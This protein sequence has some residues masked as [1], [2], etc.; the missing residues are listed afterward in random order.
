MKNISWS[1][2]WFILKVLPEHTAHNSS[3]TVSQHSQNWYTLTHMHY[4]H[5]TVLLSSQSRKCYPGAGAGEA[6]SS[7]SSLHGRQL[8]VSRRRL[9][10]TQFIGRSGGG[11]GGVCKLQGW[12]SVSPEVPPSAFSSLFWQFDLTLS[13]LQLYDKRQLLIPSVTLLTRLWLF[14]FTV[15]VKRCLC[16]HKYSWH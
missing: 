8:S 3:T 16:W 11:A 9:E 14:T 15:T 4:R 1:L 2:L 13:L 7:S 12:V 10:F 6:S 5:T